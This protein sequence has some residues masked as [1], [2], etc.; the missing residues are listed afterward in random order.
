M[1]RCSFCRKAIEQGTGTML[2]KNDGKILF[3]CSSKCDKNL[4]KLGREPRHT[5]WTGAYA[6]EKQESKK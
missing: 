3:F 6:K 4:N 5:R 1:T 2:V